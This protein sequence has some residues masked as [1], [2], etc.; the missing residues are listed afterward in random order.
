M[1]K[2]KFDRTFSIYLEAFRCTS[3]SE[4]KQ[5]TGFLCDDSNFSL[6]QIE[7]YAIAKRANGVA[8]EHNDEK[9]GVE[10][11]FRSNYDETKKKQSNTMNVCDR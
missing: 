3:E 10:R 9:N 4:K 1:T 8:F 11:I 2:F 7:I 6:A 5:Q